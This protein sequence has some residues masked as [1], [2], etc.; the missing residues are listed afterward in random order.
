MSL[1]RLPD[2][3]EGLAEASILEWHVRP[4]DSVEAGQLLVSVETAKAVV[5][6]PSP[7]SGRI[8]AL[9][10]AAGSTVPTHAPLVEFAEGADVGGPAPRGD[11]GSVVGA[12]E[13]GAAVRE[14]G[15]LI[16]RHRTPPSPAGEAGHRRQPATAAALAARAPASP[17][18]FADGEPLDPTRRHMA[19]AMA[20]A[21][22]EVVQVTLIDE[23]ALPLPARSALT[24][25]LVR[26]LVAGARAEPAL[27]AWY[28]GA[29]QQRL[30]HAA[31][32]VG[33]A[34]DTPHGLYVPVLRDAATLDAEAIASAVAALRADALAHR[35]APAQLAG[36]TLTLSNFGALGGRHATPVVLPPQVAILGA[37]RVYEGL[38]LDG[39]AVVPVHLLP[40]SLSFDHRAVTGGEAARFLAAVAADLAAP[41][42]APA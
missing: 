22:R 42:S 18:P 23:V 27:N 41:W 32:H 15:F 33:I 17:P 37:G 20:H 3:G 14:G 35:L 25:R 38:R 26:A 39:G 21:H 28:D 7:Q 19:E 31:V 9:L 8:V 12:L 4:G 34:V 24:A 40:L 10:A 6:V 13:H 36:A 11:A 29:R 2:L 1:F 16:G 5:D 30:L